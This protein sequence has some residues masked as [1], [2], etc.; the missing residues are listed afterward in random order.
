[1]DIFML[2]ATICNLKENIFIKN[3]GFSIQKDRNPFSKGSFRKI[4]LFVVS[5]FTPNL[6]PETRV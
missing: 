5:N 1:V 2:C 6:T 3:G 4:G